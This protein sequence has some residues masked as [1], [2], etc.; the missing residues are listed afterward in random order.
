MI[1]LKAAVLLTSVC[2]L[3]ACSPSTPPEMADLENSI[4]TATGSTLGTVTLKD[5]GEGGTQVT[6]SISGLDGAGTHAMHFHEFGLCDAPD[7]TSAG[8]HKNPMDMAHGK[9][10]ADGPHAG[11]MMNI[12]VGDDGTGSLT[13]IN[14]LV[15]ING[16]HGLPALLDE[17]GTALIIHEK[18]DDYITQPTGAAG[19]RIGCALIE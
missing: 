6:V 9:L 12:E 15:S 18:A 10:A 16:E 17:D 7:F 13:V 5:L 2:V 14:E 19:S 8:G 1:N 3:A 11:D 4:L